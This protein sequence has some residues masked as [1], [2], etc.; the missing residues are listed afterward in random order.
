[1]NDQG[2]KGFILACYKNNKETVDLLI[3]KYPNII[4]QKNNHG[5]TGLMKACY[6][7]NIE[8]VKLFIKR[9][10]DIIY[11]KYNGRA[12]YDY[13]NN[14]SK[15]LITKYIYENRSKIIKP[16]RY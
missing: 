4:E 15:K 16:K 10:P 8:I 2:D 11:Q 3:E 9:Y 1:M 5:R 6:Y 12:G 13:L 7:D 14:D